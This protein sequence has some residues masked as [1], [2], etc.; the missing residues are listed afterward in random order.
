ML[1]P[2]EFYQALGD[3]GVEYFTGVP[4]SLLKAFC[5][6][7]EDQLPDKQHVIAANEG[8][9][10]GL[11][12]GYHLATGKLPLV[13]L[14]NS[15][16]GNTV[17]PLLSLADPD[18]YSVPLLL[19]IGWRG[20]PGVADEPQHAKQGR[21]TLDLLTALEIPYTVI[22]SSETDLPSALEK[23][24]ESARSSGGPHALVVRKGSF[25]PF[26]S[27]SSRIATTGWSR[28][29]AIGLVVETLGEGDIVVATT[30]M[31]SRELYEY[32]ERMGQGHER[33]F[34]TVGGMG[35][36]SQI[37]MGIASQE[38]R[39]RIVCLDGDGAALMHM[40][41]LATSGVSAQANFY[42]V[43]LNNGVHDSVGGQPTVALQVDFVEIA[44]ACG[45]V[46]S[47]GCE[48]KEGAV[49]AMQSL[50]ASPGPGFLELRVDPGHR[51]DLGRPTATPQENKKAFMA[52][53]GSS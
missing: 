4:D 50:L 12:M 53:L 24:V 20:E 51:S 49:S 27:A 33:D 21:V 41:A 36:A 9:A 48:S 39:R 31:A 16:F 23:A 1:S 28:E 6:F 11:A 10:V 25:E 29:Q 13:Y 17:N 43:L 40:G 15:G 18:V 42:H 32:R 26:D 8:S 37:A 30:G 46:H 35:H 45:Y 34:L 19:M 52:F 7:L 44:S 38:P 47:T 22:D 5:H 3:V 2:K 14:Q